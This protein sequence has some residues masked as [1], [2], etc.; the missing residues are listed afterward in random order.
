MENNLLYLKVDEVK[1][2]LV[3]IRREFHSF[4][5]LG[6]KEHLTSR[7]I[8]NWLSSINDIE[9]STGVA[10]TGVVALIKG[11]ETGPTI[12][13]RVDIDAL[14]IQDAKKTDYASKNQGLCH[15]CGHDV[16]T[17]IGLGVA[18]I[19]SGMKKE[20][21]G[22]IKIIFQPSEESPLKD[23][24]QNSDPYTEF[25]VGKHAAD[26]VIE[27]GVLENPP[28]DR[29]LGIHCWPSLKVGEI[30]Y[31][32]GAAMAAAANFHFTIKGKG[33]HAARPH[34][35]ID[36]MTIT[37]QVILALQ[38]L[39]SRR[40]D[41]SCPFV[42]TLATI[43]GGTRRFNI[44]DRIDLTG[45]AR[46]FDE[47]LLRNEIPRYMEN[48]IKGISEGNEGEYVFEYGQPGSPVINDDVVVRDTVKSLR[49]IVGVNVVELK[50]APMTAEDFSSYSKKVP[51]LYIKLGTA[52][53]DKS[54]QYPLHNP[55]FDVDERCVGIG[56]L[57]IVKIILDYLK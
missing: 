52:G 53:D 42:L 57:S 39:V 47:N 34:E 41:P 36:A 38:T 12:G 33:G 20:L 54:T 48:I 21:K 2:Q 32:F 16:H 45:T 22:N 10:G 19:I 46:C 37:A 55:L 28:I 44:A 17:T 27:A 49:N 7:K 43:K 4:P 26:L 13:L 40:V 9:I 15:A 31:Q 35:A 24:T 29:L 25:S 51:S 8:V 18:K 56:V 30:G 6:F 14:P 3:A 5:E 23:D 50:D 11:A 1:S